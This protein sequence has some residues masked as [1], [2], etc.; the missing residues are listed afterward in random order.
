MSDIIKSTTTGIS[1]RTEV[2]AAR[3]ML[4]HAKPVMVLDKTGKPVRM[5]KNKGVKITFRRPNTFTAAD[6]PLQEGVTPSRRAFTYTDV[7]ATLKQYGDVSE[8]TDVIEDTHEDP[9]LNDCTEQHGENIGRTVEALNY[10]VVRAG[11]NVFY[12]NGASRAAVNTPISLKKQRAVTRALK[13]QKAMKPTK[14]L[15]PSQNF[16]TKAVEA[17]YIAVAHTDVENDI[18]EMPGFTPVADYGTMSPICQEEIGT[19]D[20]CRYIL[21]PDLEPWLDAGGSANDV[22]SNSGSNADVYPVLY[23]G[24]ESWAHIALR[25][26]GSISPSIIPVGQKTKDDP[27][28]QR[29]YVGWK[30]WHTAVITNDAWMARL[31]VAVTEL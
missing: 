17:A 3:E 5:P 2:Y 9:V 16:Q 13:A 15:G 1:Q 14:I 25:G 26:V 27:L 22:V 21:S 6:T 11:T 29:G 10:A 8:I 28:G 31:E 19:V 12:Q 23:F 20:D 30:T 7:P 24:K 4:K 18:R